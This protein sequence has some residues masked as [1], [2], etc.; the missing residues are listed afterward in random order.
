MIMENQKARDFLKSKKIIILELLEDI[1]FIE[2]KESRIC[3][4]MDEYKELHESK[5]KRTA[6][7]DYCACDEEGM[8]RYCKVHSAPVD[9]HGK[10][11]PTLDDI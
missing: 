2:D 3:E 11:K 6:G 4:L 1:E 10:Y 8:C 7:I 5:P 9:R